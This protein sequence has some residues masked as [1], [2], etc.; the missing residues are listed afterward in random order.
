MN[1]TLPDF[2]AR[3]N[4][5]MEKKFSIGKSNQ[6]TEIKFDWDSSYSL[7]FDMPK[8]KALTLLSL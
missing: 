8:K 5:E 6:Q 4:I 2:S 1:R 3:I 7:K